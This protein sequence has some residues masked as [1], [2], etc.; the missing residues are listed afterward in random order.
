MTGAVWLLARAEEE[1]GPLFLILPELKELIWG[2]AAFAV[3]VF[4][5]WKLVGPKLAETLAVRQ[6]AVTG[7]L[8][9]AERAKAEAEGLLNDYRQQLAGAK[10]EANRIIE[11]SRQSAE[12]L[13]QEL[14][15]RSQAEAERI[16]TRARAEVAAERERATTELKR[17]V[18]VLS[19][20]LA[21]RVVER[22]LDSETQR[23][24]VESYLSDLDGMRR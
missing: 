9:E 16:S 14:M 13:R 11:E 20:Q 23:A 5:V 12:Q 22:N 7:R 1:R 10:S 4:L 19:V 3:L 6:A 15:T 8:E 18:A 24:L 21:G 17:E 2:A